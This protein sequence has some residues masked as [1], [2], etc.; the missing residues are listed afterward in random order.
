[1]SEN[2][3]TFGFEKYHLEDFM[4][5]NKLKSVEEVINFMNKRKESKT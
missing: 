3:N 1:M 2:K 5:K 4:Q